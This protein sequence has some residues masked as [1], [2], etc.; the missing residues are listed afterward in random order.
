MTREMDLEG[1]H[2]LDW[3]FDEYV[4]GTALPTHKLTRVREG[5]CWGRGIQLHLDPV[6]YG[7]D[8]SDAGPDLR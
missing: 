2:K 3:F 7:S 4:Y 8:V 5:R 1:N 6:E